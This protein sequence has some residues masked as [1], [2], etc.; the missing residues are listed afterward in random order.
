MR[1]SLSWILF[2]SL[3]TL[4]PAT[5]TAWAEDQKNRFYLKSILASPIQVRRP[6][7]T[8]ADPEVGPGGVD[9]Q[10]Q[11]SLPDKSFD[12]QPA[13]SL[14]AQWND[15]VVRAC[16]ASIQK[17]QRIEYELVMTSRPYFKLRVDEDETPQCLVKNL[18]SIPVPREFF[19]QANETQIVS[20]KNE[21]SSTNQG[22]KPLR[23]DV[24][25]SRLS[26]YA[27]RLP[28]EKDKVLGKPFFPNT[29]V[30]RFDFPLPEVP[31]SQEAF[32]RMA[33]AWSLTPFYYLRD[34]RGTFEASWVPDRF[35]KVC[36]GDGK[37]HPKST[38]GVPQWP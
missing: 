6:Q 38:E 10:S 28:I 19:F 26:C 24:K 32:Y 34:D 7:T 9:Y 5:K 35:C 27:A 29:M 4:A 11:P 15:Q 2:L 14:Y 1:K 3:I 16:L 30:L 33:V 37:L 12:C 22:W 21:G 18:K 8:P 13:K 23:S 36:F 31:T 17:K 25:R 20:S